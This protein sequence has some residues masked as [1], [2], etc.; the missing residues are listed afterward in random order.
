MELYFL[1]HGRSVSRADWAEDD[2]QRPLTEDGRLDMAR[3]V[4][5]LARFGLRPDLIVTSPLRRARQTAEIVAAGLEASDRLID[6]DRLAQGFGPKRL[7]KVLR[8]HKEARHIM[9]VGHEPDFSAT[10][11]KLTGGRVLC[12]KG[13]LARVDIADIEDRHGELVWLWQAN[14]LVGEGVG[15]AVVVPA[16]PPP[17]ELSQTT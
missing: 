14:Q 12:S 3:E 17:G 6:D 13:G 10:I 16:P 2:G 1:R 4:A 5:T 15:Q 7:R 8:A 11:G 9:L